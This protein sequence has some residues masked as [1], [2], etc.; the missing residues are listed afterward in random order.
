MILIFR[1]EKPM[2]KETNSLRP[3]QSTVTMGNEN[4]YIIPA[5][6]LI[7]TGATLSYRK[8]TRKYWIG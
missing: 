3:M 5:I 8:K 4:D 2:S 7:I 1:Q 6:L